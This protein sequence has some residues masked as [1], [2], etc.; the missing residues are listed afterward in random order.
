MCLC[1]AHPIT[2]TSPCWAMAHTEHEHV[3]IIWC[4]RY[5]HDRHQQ[6]WLLTRAG[7]VAFDLRLV[8]CTFVTSAKQHASTYR[9]D[10]GPCTFVDVIQRVHKTVADGLAHADVPSMQVMAQLASQQ[11]LLPFNALPYQVSSPHDPALEC[12]QAALPC[13]FWLC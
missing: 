4:C 9:C 3:C 8:P 7:V 10:A 5:C 11:K 2:L 1:C 12:I 6:S 13:S